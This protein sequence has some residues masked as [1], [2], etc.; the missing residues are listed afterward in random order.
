MKILNVSNIFFT[1]PYFFGDQLSYF[2]SKGYDISLVCSPDINL[3]PF[4]ERHNCKYKEIYIPRVFAPCQ[5]IVCFWKLFKYISLGKFDI[6]CGHTPVGGLLAIVAAWMAG[7]KKRVFFRHGLVYETSSGIKRLILVYAEKVASRLAT[8]VVCVSPYLVEKSLSD[9]LTKKEK[10]LLLNNGSCNG[11]DAKNK[12]NKDNLD[13]NYF[14]EL[15]SKWHIDDNEFVIGYTGR[16]VRDKGVEELV[17]AFKLINI[18]YPKCKL[19]LVGMLEE[20]DAISSDTIK[21]IRNNPNIVHTGLILGEIE[22]YY[23]MMDVLV[24]CTHREGFGSVLIEAAAMEVPTLTTSH[25]G[26]RDAIC[27]N[28]TGQ[29]IIMNNVN[30]IVEKVTDYIED[31]NLRKKHGIQGRKWVL[32][33]FQ[34]EIIWA[35]IEKKIYL[36]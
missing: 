12:F 17:S 3:K 2:S 10:L 34:Q 5:V 24:L 4:A 26:S 15:C 20:R 23:A 29:F 6:V 9:G 30:S 28:V 21:E 8:Q 13:K 31:E 1:L 25:S 27:E 35:E 36:C 19:L 18:K 14:H 33:N 16:L 32:E 11:V 7:V 22:Y